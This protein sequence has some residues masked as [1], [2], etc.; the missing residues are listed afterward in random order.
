M[1][2]RSF[3]DSIEKFLTNEQWNKIR[4]NLL[5]HEDWI[6][7][8]ILI[9]I[10]KPFNKYSTKLQAK[11]CGLSDFYGYWL[12]I[13]LAMK[14]LNNDELVLLILDE[15]KNREQSLFANP[16][17]ISAVYMDPRYQRTLKDN[18][19]KLAIYFLSQLYLKIKRIEANEENPDTNDTDIA[20]GNRINISNCS[21]TSE[22]LADFLNNFEAGQNQNETETPENWKQYI[23]SLL[24]DF[25][26]TNIPL[27]IPVLDFWKNEKKSKP[28]LH[29]L[30]SVIY[31]VQ[32][33]QTSVERAFSIFSLILT[34]RRTRLSD[35]NLQNI[36]CIKLNNF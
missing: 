30:A 29:M 10:L 26:G 16:V 13:Q 8:E 11:S 31:V 28:E 22:D 20:G 33:T 35:Q 2:L 15:M 6:E 3:L 4:G 27:S 9:S 36:L 32:A 14:K 7:V 17:M 5:T 23:E 24:K 25:D 19:K 1:E 21:E 12:S 18:Q 34:S